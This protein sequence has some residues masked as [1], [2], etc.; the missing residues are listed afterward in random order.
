MTTKAPRHQSLPAAGKEREALRKKGQFWTPDW[1]AEAMVAYATA[2]GAKT[3]YDPAVGGGAFFRAA[4]TISKEIGRKFILAGSELHHEVL[5]DAIAGGLTRAD[6]A[7]VTERDFVMQPP[8]AT[9]ECIVANPPYLRHHRLPPDMKATLREFGKNLTGTPLD[10]RAGFHI[11]FLLRALTLLKPSGRLAFVMPADTCEG[12]FAR[13]LWQWITKKFRLDAVLTF[14]HEATPFPG[15]DTNAVVFLI[16]REPPADEFFWASCTERNDDLKGW[17]LSDLTAEPGPTL[18]VIETDI[19]EGVARGLSRP[20]VPSEEGGAILSD[21]ATVM[22]GIATG[23]NEFFHLTHAEAKR[24][25]IPERFFVPAIG[26]TRDASGEKFTTEML[27]ALDAEGRA[28]LLL[29]LDATPMDRLPPSVQ[30]YLRVGEELD[31]PQRSLIASRKPWYRMEV[32][33]IPSF[34]FA[35]LGRRNARFIRNEAGVVP[36]TGFLCVYPK[37][38][39]PEAIEKLWNMLNHPDTIARLSRVGKS[40][41]GGAI[42]VE[43]RGLD[44]L[45]IPQHVLELVGAEQPEGQLACL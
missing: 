12:V 25:A 36:L 26:R 19:E 8:D 34:L 30:R 15:V 1:L 40:Y 3:V 42:K 45:S 38:T 20:P 37:D 44:R 41:G 11:Y 22:R 9:F 27:D 7:R 32:R 2:G 6:L 35:Y 18:S 5:S 14:T 4:K 24:L 43:P 28:T 31:L 17:L 21:F 29:T 39:R 33:K 10:G 13:P 23:A 16:R